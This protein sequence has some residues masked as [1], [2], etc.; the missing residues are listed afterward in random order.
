MFCVLVRLIDIDHRDRQE[1]HHRRFVTSTPWHQFKQLVVWFHVEVES[2][3]A[4]PS[5]Q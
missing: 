3:L 1:V 5:S 2:K 4:V